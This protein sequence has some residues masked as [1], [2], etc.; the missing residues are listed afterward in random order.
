MYKLAGSIQF[1]GLVGMLALVA[2][3]A[4]I[5]ADDPEPAVQKIFDKLLGAIKTAD[6]EAF[7]ADGTEAVKKG[8]TQEIMDALKKDMGA[9][10][11]KGYQARYL[12]ELKQAGHQV[13]L[14]KATFKDAGDD[15]VIRVALKDGK[16]AGFFL[17]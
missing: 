8:T 13:Y 14:W 4:P 17:Q 7:V 12:C 5:K 6:L 16:V 11:D 1:V 9:R 3:I 10:L 2:V 15:L